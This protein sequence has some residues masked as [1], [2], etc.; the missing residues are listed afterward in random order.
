LLSTI[1]D[2]NLGFTR[3]SGVYKVGAKQQGRAARAPGNTPGLKH[4]TVR[5]RK[6]NRGKKNKPDAMDD[7]DEPV[8]KPPRV[9]RN[10]A[11]TCLTFSKH[12][13]ALYPEHFFCGHCDD[14]ER[15]ISMLSKKT[16]RTS[17]QFCC[18]AMHFS[19]L[20]PTQLKKAYHPSMQVWQQ[21]E[22]SEGSDEEY[23]WS[24]NEDLSSS[25]E[26]EDLSDIDEDWDM[27]KDPEPAD[28]K[29]EERQHLLETRKAV[30]CELLQQVG[31]ARRDKQ[32]KSKEQT[33]ELLE[34]QVQRLQEKVE[35]LTKSLVAARQNV[36]RLRH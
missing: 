2:T 6:S 13:K 19:P 4:R 12:R 15:D 27:T 5:H 3:G 31:Q 9:T 7:E 1:S 22:K 11:V 34:N 17:N 33:T 23:F 35:L 14:W 8:T 18:E 36:D 26:D 25:N 29:A 30:E 21:D 20:M 24:D 10:T 28:N 16:K 32:A